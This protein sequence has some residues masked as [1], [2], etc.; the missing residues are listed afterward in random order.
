MVRYL[1][2]TNIISEPFKPAPDAQVMSQLQAHADEVAIASITWHELLYGLNR[3]ASSR[4]KQQLEQYLRETN[5]VILSFERQAAEWFA[6]E[7]ARLAG[8]GQSPSYPDGQIAAIAAVN[9]LVLVTWNVSDFA[10]F[11]GLKLE[12]W[13]G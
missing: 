7:R 5:F 8:I 9:D 1:A 12:N 6:V 2:D 10:N 3:M 13:F 4:R 11:V